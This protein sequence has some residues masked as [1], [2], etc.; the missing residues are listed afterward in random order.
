LTNSETK[1]IL[2]ED[3]TVQAIDLYKI[4]QYKDSKS[5]WQWAIRNKL[6]DKQIYEIKQLARLAEDKQMYYAS[7]FNMSVNGSYN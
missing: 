7:I 6:I 4:G 2:T 5:I 3:T 1:N